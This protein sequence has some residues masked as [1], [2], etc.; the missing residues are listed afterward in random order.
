MRTREGRTLQSLRAVKAFLDT[1][2]SALGDVVNTGA[3]RRLDDVIA[4]L[5]D[6]VATQVGSELAA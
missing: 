1:N 5:A 3:R 6:Q 4:A 2:A